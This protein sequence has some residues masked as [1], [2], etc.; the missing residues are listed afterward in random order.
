MQP[1]GNEFFGNVDPRS[2]RKQVVS[3]E[4][5][6]VEEKHGKSTKFKDSDDDSSSDE[7]PDPDSRGVI[8]ALN[9]K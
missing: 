9:G 4:E 2:S 3:T 1:N 7:E 8:M 6:A 5:E